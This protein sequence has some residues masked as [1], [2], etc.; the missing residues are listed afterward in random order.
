M[1]QAKSTPSHCKS[2]EFG[3]YLRERRE[4]L[5][6]DGDRRW[7]LRRVADEAG[8]QPSYLSRIERRKEAPPSEEKIRR[9]AEILGEDPDVLLGIAGRVSSDVREI[10]AKRPR[11]FAQLI[12]EIRDLPDH[13]VIRIVRE[14]RDGQW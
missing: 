12:R 6:R 2:E 13:A 10:I 4:D 8:L 14:V 11:L 9:L 5:R 7:S 3:A 1:D